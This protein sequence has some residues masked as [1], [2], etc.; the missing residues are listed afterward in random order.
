MFSKLLL[1]AALTLTS[2]QVFSQ[3][4]KDASK[5]EEKPT[6]LSNQNFAYTAFD[7]LKKKFTVSYHG[8]YYFTRPDIMSANEDDH[9]LSDMRIMHNPTIIYRPVENWK[10]LATSEFK[11]TDALAQGSFINRHYRSLV[12]LTRE[13]LLLEKEHGFRLDAGVGRRI[14]D[15]HWPGRY[16]NSRAFVTLHKTWM[17]KHPSTLTVQYLGNDPVTLGPTTWEHGLNILPTITFQITDKIAWL[18]NDDFVI[19]F[20]WNEN[21]NDYTLSHDMNIGY[22]TY[23]WDDKNSSYFQAKYLH[24]D[25]FALKRD[26]SD[27]FDYYIGHSYSFTPKLTVT[28]EVGSNVFAS[29]DGRDFFSKNIEYPEFALYLDWAL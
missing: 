20:P 24:T 22:I 10:L 13:K 11:Y 18:F 9:D 1:L 7:Y 26:S 15:A 4:A 3:D 28:G 29:S 17:A 12:T 2:T 14:F 23:Q 19:N 16:G 8:E 6:D 27:T 21:A 25:S 5:K